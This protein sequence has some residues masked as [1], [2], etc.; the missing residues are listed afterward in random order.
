MGAVRNATASLSISVELHQER[1]SHDPS[2]CQKNVHSASWLKTRLFTSSQLSSTT[3]TSCNT[4]SVSVIAKLRHKP[5]KVKQLEAFV[6]Q[7]GTI[8]AVINNVMM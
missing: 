6:Q 5:Q 2:Q 8:S 3:G 4:V 7:E 1:Y